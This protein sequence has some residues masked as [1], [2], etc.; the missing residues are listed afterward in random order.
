MHCSLKRLFKLLTILVYSCILGQVVA[1]PPRL[2]G[3]FVVDTTNKELIR[4][5]SSDLGTFIIE[6]N[7]TINVITGNVVFEHKGD[8]LYADSARLDLTHNVVHAYGHV[9]VE[10]T[11]GTVAY[12][13]RMYY[14]G[15]TKNVELVGNVELQSGTDFLWSDKIDYNLSSQIGRYNHGG[16]L[17]SGSTIIQ[18]KQAVY[19]G[20]TND[21]R[22]K[23]DVNV[24]DPE[25]EVVS[26][27]LGYNTDT[28]VVTFLGP[29]I[30][31]NDSS[32]LY[33]SSGTYDS[34]NEIAIFKN[35]SSITSESQYM[36]ADSMYYNRKTG[37]GIGT[38]DVLV[39]DSSRNIT[40]YC[41][42]ATVN[43]LTKQVM[44]TIKPYAVMV[45]D[46]D[47]T[48]VKAD[49]FFSEPKR[50]LERLVQ[51][52]TAQDS[53]LQALDIL[54][55]DVYSGRLLDSTLVQQLDS[56]HLLHPDL[57][58]T[59]S[60][61]DFRNPSDSALR[62]SFTD[63]SLIDTFLQSDYPLTDID[64]QDSLDIH[65]VTTSDV[66]DSLSNAVIP[67]SE[68]EYE[69]YSAAPTVETPEDPRYFI[70]YRNVLVYND[71]FQARADSMSYSQEDSL[72]QFF[73]RPVFWTR[74][75]QITGDVII[76]LVDT[77]QLRKITIPKNGIIVNQSTEANEVMFDQIQGN[78]I[79]AYFSNNE[80]DS[81]VAV[82]NAETI[83]YIT[84]EE[85][86]YV[87][88]S[89]AMS[90]DLRIDFYT[91][92]HHNRRAIKQITYYKEVQQK[93]SPL[94]QVKPESLRLN[95]FVWRKEERIRTLEE[96]FAEVEQP[97]KAKDKLHKE[98][99]RD[100]LIRL[101]N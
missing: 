22:F 13:D 40:V 66:N 85:D 35:R 18:S 58:D 14:D 65:R 39:V 100:Q 95:R 2:P 38:G 93:T 67:W 64:T 82:G 72:M 49:T 69:G 11:D 86:A 83:Y 78:R 9:K 71:S 16:T 36:E 23:G 24:L 76:A 43:E 96:F 62:H 45:K 63:S 4:L 5:V 12:A 37:L 68:E 26:A 33:T 92:T 46:G 7:V 8:R 32:T 30:I 81:V 10:Q 99:I 27:E 60:P 91:D 3:G 21:A 44:A 52:L 75:T 101:E 57:V 29:S 42:F 51:P 74:N 34:E 47:T 79:Y 90:G 28:R 48:Y 20:K 94:T 1:Q 77:Q 88:V 84:D 87:G 17:Q 56:I 59:V 61:F 19:Y 41:Q 73:K 54:Y 50:N 15:N 97:G 25:Y 53:L 31:N 6:D 55:R 98:E 70:A 80:I 89:Q